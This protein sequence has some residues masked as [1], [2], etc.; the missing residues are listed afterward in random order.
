MI[1]SLM[2]YDFPALGAAHARYWQAIRH[3]LAVRGIDSPP[4]LSQSAEE[5]SVWRNPALVL[6]QTCGM[7]YRLFL[8][9]Q[10]TYVGTPV[11]GIDGCPPGY[12]RSALVVRADDPRTALNDYRTARFAY[13]QTISQSGW[14]A[15]YEHLRSGGWWFNDFHHSHGHAKS[16]HA[17]AEGRADIASLD[18]Q[19]WALIRQHDPVADRLRVLDWTIPTPGLPYIAG[20]SA[21]ASLTSQAVASAIDSLSAADRTALCLRGLVQFPVAAYLEVPTPPQSAAP[22]TV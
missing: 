18:A 14:A 15:P 22:A 9:D 6:S 16:A 11:F 21:D 10:V 17:V 5:F 8:H 4:K 3:E 13:N 19:T 12:Y 20:P 1:A 2:M 7:P